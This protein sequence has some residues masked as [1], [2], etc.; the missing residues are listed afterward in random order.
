MSICV[1]A[2]K[3]FIVYKE[4]EAMKEYVDRYCVKHNL[5]LHKAINHE[6]VTQYRL[7]LTGGKSNDIQ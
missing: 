7:M 3:N 5:S 6:M 1:N 2:V 4:N